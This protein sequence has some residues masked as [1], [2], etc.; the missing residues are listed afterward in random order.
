MPIPIQLLLSPYP[1]SLYS[2]CAYTY[3]VVC[4]KPAG[5][6]LIYGMEYG[7]ECGMDWNGMIKYHVTTYK[8]QT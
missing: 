4:L 1:V 7:L 6:S 3:S 2:L 5:V 8:C